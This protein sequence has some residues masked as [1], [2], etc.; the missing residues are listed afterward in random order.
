LESALQPGTRG[1][2]TLSLH[3]TTR[4][5]SPPR[6]PWVYPHSSQ[7]FHPTAGKHQCTTPARLLHPGVCSRRLFRRWARPHPELL[8]AYQ[9]RFSHV[10]LALKQHHHGLDHGISLSDLSHT[11]IQF[12]QRSV[13]LFSVD[14]R[15]ASDEMVVRSQKW[16]I[17]SQH[18]REHF[19]SRTLI[20]DICQHLM[21]YNADFDLDDSFASLIRCRL[22]HG[23]ADDDYACM[24]LHRCPFCPME[25]QIDVVDFEERGT[26]ICATK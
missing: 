12:V 25:Y 1:S 11:D 21:T 10:Q 18:P 24:R 8:S 16:V 22:G 23:A 2:H 6:M 20:H 26:A 17:S 19:L 7:Q 9:L 15:I 5:P 3:S 13:F 4:S 14:A